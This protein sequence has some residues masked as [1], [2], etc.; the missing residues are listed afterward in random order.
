MD[1][2]SDMS[3]QIAEATVNNPAPEAFTDHSRFSRSSNMDSSSIESAAQEVVLRE[4][5][6]AMQQVIHTQRQAR[7]TNECLEDDKDI[8]SERYDPNALKGV[9]L[10]MATDHRA[11]MVTKRG[12]TLPTISGQVLMTHKHIELS[13][14][15]RVTST[16][17]LLPSGVGCSSRHV[18]AG[19]SI[20]TLRL[21]SLARFTTPVHGN[22]EIGNGYGVP[23]GG[24]YYAAIP[25][26]DES[27]GVLSEMEPEAKGTQRELPE[28]LKRKLKARGILRD[29]VR[30][31]GTTAEK[32]SL[33][34]NNTSVPKLP[35]GWAEAKDPASGSTYFYNENTGEC[36]WER[37]AECTTSPRP[38]VL[39]SLPDDWEEALDN[40]TGQKYYY[41][42]KT[43]VSQWER[44]TSVGDVP[45]Q[46]NQMV[47]A[48]KFTNGNHETSPMLKCMRCG[49]WGVGLVQQWGYCNH[50]TR[51]LNLPAQSY[52]S[53]YNGD[54]QETSKIMPKSSSGCTIPRQ[55]HVI[56][57]VLICQNLV[58]PVYSLAHLLHHKHGSQQKKV[59]S[60]E[61][62]F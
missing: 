6:I 37:P 15:L 53:P 5:E 13:M 27:H 25:L 39:Q 8:L 60:F 49:G 34:T 4:Q 31:D 30:G 36:Q 7:S 3:T 11:E 23:G 26:S 61:A 18:T 56:I 20:S 29:D 44:P 24:A 17:V 28:Y 55:R 51:V 42:T 33:S 62:G 22:V 58:N 9:L 21:L 52:A 47:S 19:N 43:H 14:W 59:F 38:P 40:S 35:S 57:T 2:Q 32:E 45:Q 50:C 46:I 16:S 48:A 1:P 10:K 54:H 41:N 12:K